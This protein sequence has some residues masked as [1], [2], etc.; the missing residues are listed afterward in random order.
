MKIGL[1]L[2]VLRARAGM[3]QVQLAKKAKLSQPTIAFI[4]CD[5]KVPN[6]NTVEK[7]A[8]ALKIKTSYFFLK[9]EEGFK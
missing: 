6:I 5:R 9:V 2:Q 1:T 7:I 4:E 8:K 3:S